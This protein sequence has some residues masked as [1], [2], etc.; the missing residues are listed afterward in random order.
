MT[1]P[2]L[3]RGRAANQRSLTKECRLSKVD[4][5]K[6]F[7]IDLE[8]QSVRYSSQECTRWVKFQLEAGKILGIQTQVWHAAFSEG[9]YHIITTHIEAAREDK[10]SRPYDVICVRSLRHKRGLGPFL[11]FTRFN[12]MLL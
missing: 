4:A 8:R 9:G 2:K 12:V 6:L 11:I 1:S 5:L 10:D 7:A 3:L